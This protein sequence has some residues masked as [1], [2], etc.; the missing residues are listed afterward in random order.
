MVLSSPYAGF[1]F[2]PAYANEWVAHKII[3]IKVVA[4][5]FIKPNF[6]V[7]SVPLSESWTQNCH[8][9]LHVSIIIWQ[10]YACNKYQHLENIGIAVWLGISVTPILPDFDFELTAYVGN[11]FSLCIQAFLS[12]LV[13]EFNSASIGSILVLLPPWLVYQ[14]LPA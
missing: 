8:P 11:F 12:S 9:S 2:T 14:C 6:D 1:F 4:N 7:L 10:N 13:L 5:T 3:I